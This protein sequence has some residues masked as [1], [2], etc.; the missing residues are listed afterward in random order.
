MA[1][2]CLPPVHVQWLVSPHCLWAMAQLLDVPFTDPVVG[3]SWHATLSLPAF[4]FM[5][6]PLVPRAL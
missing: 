3:L 6:Q 1:G 5:V 4:S 2:P